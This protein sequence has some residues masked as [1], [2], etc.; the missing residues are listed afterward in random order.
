MYML[1][2]GATGLILGQFVLAYRLAGRS[3]RSPVC[4]Q[5]GHVLFSVN[6]IV[7]LDE[8]DEMIT[9]PQSRQ[10]SSV[11]QASACFLPLLPDAVRFAIS[12]PQRCEVAQAVV[13]T[14]ETG[15]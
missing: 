7:P 8:D 1:V 14:G 12:R 10:V 3:A 9:N 13:N 5:S 11:R 15:K 6:Q 4:L 2:V